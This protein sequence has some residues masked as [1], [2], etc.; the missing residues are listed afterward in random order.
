MII[1][2]ENVTEVIILSKDKKGKGQINVRYRYILLSYHALTS[3]YEHQKN[4]INFK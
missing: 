4:K 1:I 2:P 3:N